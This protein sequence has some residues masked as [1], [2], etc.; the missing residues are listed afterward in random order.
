M[1]FSQTLDAQARNKLPLRM[2]VAD[3]QALSDEELLAHSLK[4]P[5]AFEALM[6]RYQREFVS[7]AMVVVKVKDDAED[8]VQETFIRI[9]RFAPKYNTE[10]GTFRAWS[11]TILMNVARTHYQKVAKARGTFVKLEDEHYVS[12]ADPHS[13]H[14]DYLD[15]EEVKRVLSKVDADT[16]EILTLAYI[17]ALPYEEIAELKQ[18]SVG[19]IKARVHRAKI[20]VR[21]ALGTKGV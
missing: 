1:S 12:L 5:S 6:I 4:S 19:A 18:T 17:E 9:Y 10:N 7:R 2:A 13:A 11:I 16:A 20:A 14:N 8:V 3:Y 21:N 15:A